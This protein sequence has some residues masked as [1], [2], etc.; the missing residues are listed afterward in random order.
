[1]HIEKGP[2]ITCKWTK[3]VDDEQ[4]EGHHRKIVE[5]S[6][7]LE[8]QKGSVNETTPSRAYSSSVSLEVFLK[9][10]FQFAFWNMNETKDTTYKMHQHSAIWKRFN[11]T[12]TTSLTQLCWFTIGPRSFRLGQEVNL[13]PWLSRSRVLDDYAN[14]KSWTNPLK[15]VKLM[16]KFMK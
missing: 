4:R 12:R 2:D 10:I 9:C 5:V 1:M 8:S 15:V 16:G 6:G 14:K 13:N 3:T 7:F 11:I